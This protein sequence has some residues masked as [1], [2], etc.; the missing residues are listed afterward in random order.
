MTRVYGDS[1]KGYYKKC[2]YCDKRFFKSSRISYK[3]FEKRRFCRVDCCLS[4]QRAQRDNGH[5]QKIQWCLECFRPFAE[6]SFYNG[7]KRCKQCINMQMDVDKFYNI[8]EN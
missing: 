7:K 6:D 3:V 4:S 2:A 8:W 1:Y 5:Q